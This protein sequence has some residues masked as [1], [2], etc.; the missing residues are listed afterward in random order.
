M[1]VYKYRMMDDYYIWQT[2]WLK[3]SAIFNL[4]RYP[5]ELGSS[6]D[7]WKRGV[8]DASKNRAINPGMTGLQTREIYRHYLNQLKD[9]TRSNA[10]VG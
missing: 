4:S 5:Q 8:D 2:V 9:D 1:Y 6:S 10:T 3:W 7:D